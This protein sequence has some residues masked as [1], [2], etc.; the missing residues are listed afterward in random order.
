MVAFFEGGA[1]A[2][3]LAEDALA[4]ADAAAASGSRL[5]DDDGS[6]TVFGMDEVRLLAPEPRPRRIRDY[7]TY[8]RARVRLRADGSA[9]VRGHADLLQVQHRNGDRP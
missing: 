6:P 2:R 1:T 9:G 4:A 3:G 5:V 8:T 7:L